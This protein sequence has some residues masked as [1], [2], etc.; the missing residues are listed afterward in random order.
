RLSNSTMSRRSGSFPGQ[1]GDGGLLDPLRNRVPTDELLVGHLIST[2]LQL[3]HQ[4]PA[5]AVDRQHLVLCAVRDEE[6]RG[7]VAYPSRVK[8][9][10]KGHDGMEDVTVGDAQRQRVG[11]TVGEPGHGVAA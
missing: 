3:G 1:P 6:P 8:P 9:W 4:T 11:G 7:T 10:R 2:A 5:A